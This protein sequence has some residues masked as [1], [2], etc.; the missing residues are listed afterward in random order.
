MT[1]TGLPAD[2]EPGNAE[3][4]KPKGREVSQASHRSSGPDVADM[5]IIFITPTEAAELWGPRVLRMGGMT[6]LFNDGQCKLPL[7][8]PLAELIP[9][10]STITTTSQL[11]CCSAPGELMR[12]STRA[13]R[14]KGQLPYLPQDA[15]G[16]CI[17][18]L[19]N[20]MYC[21]LA[22]VRIC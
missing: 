8:S 1:S 22:S 17:K 18:T 9:Q 6:W 11:S 12:P 15:L 19:T 5:Q 21:A 3:A 20:G 14:P 13:S 7:G 16:S 2:N 10:S 4:R